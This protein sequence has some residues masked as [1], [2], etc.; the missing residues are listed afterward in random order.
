MPRVCVA[1]IAGSDPSGGAGLQTDLRVFTLLGAYGQAVVTA[2]TVQNSLG[3]KS[4]TPVTADEVRAQLEAIFED[5]PPVAV[6]TGMLGTKAN[7]TAITE[8]LE[9]EKPLL[10]VD[11]VLLAKRGESLFEKGARQAFE[12][13]FSLATVITPNLPEAEALLGERI[14][15]PE[16]ALL[17]LKALGPKNII[18]KGGHLEGEEA[19]DLIF[20]G[21]EVTAISAPKIKG[22]IGHG[23][24]CTFSAALTV[25]LAQ[26][27]SLPE[28]ARLAKNFVTLGLKAASISPL[29]Q[30]ISPLDHLIHLDR[31]KARYE[32]LKAL[33]EAAQFFCNF[34]VRDLIPEVQSNLGYAIPLAQN[35]QEVA[36]FP[37][38]IVACGEGAH[39]VGCP[40]FGAS[41][42]IAN[43]ILAAQKFDP[44][45]R[46]AM[47]I[48]FHEKFL[49]K[50]RQLGYQVA[51]FSRQ[52][53]PPEIKAREG[54][55][56]SWGVS[57]VCERLGSVPDFIA[58]RGDVG[59]EPMIR[60]LGRD[61]LEVVQK[62]LKLLS[63]G[64]A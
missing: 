51:E 26:G 30:G 39:P 60:I 29:G 53:E 11:P 57:Q 44:E 36:A 20:D 32:V 61:P 38:R 56:L 1:T 12:R 42:H 28:A 54:S 52:E 22:N 15:D 4:W 8:I 18:L 64:N 2:L 43:V 21:R 50:A 41:R 27:L 46:A 63:G 25:G 62:A 23:T 37:G 45:M 31:L 19:V 17:K 10:V 48:R 49:K 14:T 6:K 7:L 3:V 34:P 59:K 58:D 55:T 40:R 33:E 9:R 24:G 35:Q 13:L 47:N 5:F 16:K